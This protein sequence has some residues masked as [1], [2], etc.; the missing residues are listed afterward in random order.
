MADFL[1]A[2]G[3]VMDVARLD[4]EFRRK[5]IGQGIQVVNPYAVFLH[6]PD[7][8]FIVPV[9]IAHFRPASPFGTVVV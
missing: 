8:G 1:R 9:V 3:L 6:H 7:G 5:T 4:E 2:L